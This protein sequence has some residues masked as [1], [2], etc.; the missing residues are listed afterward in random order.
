MV[1]MVASSSTS[2]G[3]SMPIRLGF[4]LADLVVLTFRFVIVPLVRFVVVPLAVALFVLVVRA[5]VAS[6]AATQ[7]GM[8][9]YRAAVRRRAALRVRA[10]VRAR[11]AAAIAAAPCSPP[12]ML[13]DLVGQSPASVGV[14]R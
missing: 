3:M 2:T 12:V 6:V 7:R 1:R 8:V 10:R 14:T 5:V 13:A 11:P 4:A 9:R